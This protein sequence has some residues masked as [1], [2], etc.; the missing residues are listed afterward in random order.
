MA[1]DRA[2]SNAKRCCLRK[3]PVNLCGEVACLVAQVGDADAA[4][5]RFRE[6]QLRRE[7]PD[8]HTFGALLHACAQIGH[9]TSA[10]RVL[11]LMAAAGIPPNVQARALFP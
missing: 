3:H 8:A 11:Q 1:V 10:A 7:A 9:H 6:M 2:S 5:A 4:F